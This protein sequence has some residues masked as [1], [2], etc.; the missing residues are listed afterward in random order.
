MLLRR[1]ANIVREALASQAAVALIGP[2][3]AGKTT[4]ALSIAEE[5]ASLYLDLEAREDRDK[6][7]EAALFID[8]GRRRGRRTGRFLILGS[9]SMDLLRQSGEAGLPMWIWRRSMSW[10][11]SAATLT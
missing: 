3:Q 8:Q 5:A 11:R 10:K 6:L 9:A 4:L 7:T 1:K 2:R